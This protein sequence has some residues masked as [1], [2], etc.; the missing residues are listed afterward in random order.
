MTGWVILYGKTIIR[1]RR[2]ERLF[3]DGGMGTSLL[4]RRLSGD[5]MRLNLSQGDKITEIHKQYLAAG[6]TVLT[7][8]TFGAYTHKYPDAAEL[9]KLAVSYGKKAREESG[10]HALVALDMG[11]LGKMLEPY[12]DMSQDEAYDIF[13]QWAQTGAAQ[14]ADMVLIETFFCINEIEAAV[15]AAKT[16][17][18][19][20]FATMTFD[21]KGR[22]T[23]GKSIRDMVDLLESL[24]VDALG[25][26]CGYGP[27]L[28]KELLPDLLAVTKLP[29]LVQPNAGLPEVV[30]GI[31]V[32][33]L[34]PEDFAQTM[35]D[36]ASL[37]CTH[38]GGCCG[39]T[40]AHIAAMVEA[41]GAV[42]RGV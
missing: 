42:A 29:V 28:Y 22:T 32:Y 38:L 19:P 16:T 39:T 25:M 5:P 30:D 13:L 41:C 6:A 36:I 40:P 7:A 17:G 35:A 2:V 37:G 27:D 26:N 11:P 23:M 33:H 21:K 34:S 20:V 4:A 3:F 15:K 24:G 9:I 8:N 31:M 12:G 1:V 14:G 10:A 18:L